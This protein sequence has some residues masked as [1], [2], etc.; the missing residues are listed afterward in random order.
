MEYDVVLADSA[1]ADADSIYRR[2]AEAAPLRGPE[3]F[4]ELL[5]V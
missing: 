4:E 2:V 5:E 1:K 3:W